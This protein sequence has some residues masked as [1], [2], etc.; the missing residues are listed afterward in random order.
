MYQHI[1]PKQQAVAVT[2]TNALD[3]LTLDQKVARVTAM[4]SDILQARP[5]IELPALPAIQ[6][7]VVRTD[8]V[9]DGEYIEA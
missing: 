8:D 4:H 5:D 6:G 3:G 7:E 9:V 2:V 1:L